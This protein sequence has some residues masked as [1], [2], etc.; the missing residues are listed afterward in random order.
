MDTRYYTGRGSRE[1]TAVSYLPNVWKNI[2]TLPIGFQGNELSPFL[3][4]GSGGGTSRFNQRRGKGHIAFCQIENK[5]R[6]RR[7]ISPHFV[8]RSFLN[9]EPAHHTV[10]WIEM[11][12]ALRRHSLYLMSFHLF[13][14]NPGFC[15]K[16]VF[17]NEG[18][19]ATAEEDR[20]SPEYRKLSK[21]SYRGCRIRYK[22]L[23]ASKSSE[24]P[25]E[26]RQATCMKVL[27]CASDSSTHAG[28]GGGGLSIPILFFAYSV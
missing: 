5:D 12:R 18:K 6:W 20:R 21:V 11:A 16:I 14:L 8:F 7:N 26:A 10:V 13:P 1:R 28:K 23:L 3:L 17:E 15:H 19:T 2:P 9:L 4:S 25:E 22:H 27:T 24:L